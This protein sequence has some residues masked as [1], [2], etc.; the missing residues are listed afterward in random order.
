MTTYLSL[1]ETSSRRNSGLHLVRPAQPASQTSN[2]RF[3]ILLIFGAV[4]DQ[5]R[6]WL[7]IESAST[8]DFLP[9][10]T[11]LRLHV[12]DTLEEDLVKSQATL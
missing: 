11:I 6:A 3:S 7:T 1:K 8:E 5:V 2:P 10:K 12:R 9:G 4:A